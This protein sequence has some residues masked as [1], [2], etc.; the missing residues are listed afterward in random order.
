MTQPKSNLPLNATRR[1]ILIGGSALAV[2]VFA[3]FPGKAFAATIDADGFLKL[4]KTLTGH[5]DL[6]ADD[7]MKMFEAFKA[8][9]KSDELAALADGEANPELG[10]EVVASWYSGVSPDPD[11]EEVI[12]YTEALMW[13]AMSYT[14]PMGYCGGATGYWADPPES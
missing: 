8:I 1:S 9:G 12:T 2:S 3:Q 6:S 7:A 4:S 11:A 5:S 14:K 10:N 13:P